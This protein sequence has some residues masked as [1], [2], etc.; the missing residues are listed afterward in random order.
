MCHS[1]QARNP[2]RGVVLC[3]LHSVVRSGPAP[4]PACVFWARFLGAFPRRVFDD[5]PVALSPLHASCIRAPTKGIRIKGEIGAVT[6]WVGAGVEHVAAGAGADR[7]QRG[8]ALDPRRLPQCRLLGSTTATS[9]GGRCVCHGDRGAGKLRGRAHVLVARGARSAR[10]HFHKLVHAS[11][12]TRGVAVV[13]APRRLAHPF[14]K[15]SASS[16]PGPCVFV[17]LSGRG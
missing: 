6:G 17:S 15:P 12:V 8:A 16:R 7:Q 10:R 4:P 2:E 1:E 14:F 9:A 13:F 3:R 5:L 11:V